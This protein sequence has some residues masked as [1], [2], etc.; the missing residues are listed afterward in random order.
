MKRPGIPRPAVDTATRNR[1]VDEMIES[2]VEWREECATVEATY[3]RWS[4]APATDCAISFASYNAALDREE[5]AASLYAADVSRL[6]RVL[7]PRLGRAPARSR[8]I[9]AA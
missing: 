2:Y 9:R 6:E 4:T 7:W 1:L 8:S 5:S 3:R